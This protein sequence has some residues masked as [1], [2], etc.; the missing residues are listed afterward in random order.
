MLHTETVVPTRNAGFNRNHVFSW[1]F[2]SESGAEPRMGQYACGSWWVAPAVGETGVRL[3]SLVGSQAPM[4]LELLQLSVNPTPSTH[5][6]IY[7]QTRSI[8]SSST[9]GGAGAA[10]NVIGSLPQLYTADAN[11]AISLVACHQLSEQDG[12]PVQSG[13]FSVSTSSPSLQEYSVRIQDAGGLDETVSYTLTTATDVALRDGLLSALQANAN[14]VAAVNLG[15]SGDDTVTFSSKASDDIHVYFPLNTGYGS[16]NTQVL[17]NANR[18]AAAG[19][20]NNL[21]SQAAAYNV[22]TVLRDAPANNGVNHIR[23]NVCG[24]T[25]DILTWDDFDLDLVPTHPNASVPGGGPYTTGGRWRFNCSFLGMS[26]WNGSDSVNHSEG[27][28]AFKPLDLIADY[29]ANAAVTWNNT[30]FGIMSDNITID[31]KKPLLAGLITFGI[32]HWHLRYNL[33]SNFAVWGSGA[34]QRGDEFGPFI[35]SICLLRDKSKIYRWQRDIATIWSTNRP[36]Q[37]PQILKQTHRGQTG[38]RLWGDGWPYAA[39]KQ[40][41][42]WS[43]MMSNNYYEGA[44]GSPDGGEGQRTSADPFGYHEGPSSYPGSNYAMVTAGGYEAIA[45][46]MMLWPAFREC[47][48]TDAPIEYIDRWRRL[49]TWALPDPIAPP[50]ETDQQNTCNTFT[51]GLTCV[52]YSITW[53]HQFGNERYGIRGGNNG[54]YGSLHGLI[55]TFSN[56][57]SSAQNA[58]AY[59]MSLYNGELMEDYLVAVDEL[60]K[61]DMHLYPHPDDDGKMG[62]HMETGSFEAEVRYTYDGSDPVETSPLFN[63]PVYFAEGTLLKARTF[64]SGFSPSAIATKV[65]GLSGE[66]KRNKQ[67]ADGGSL[68][69]VF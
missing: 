38:V 30:I 40:G 67:L 64:K 21:G 4:I 57:S 32:N 17:Q 61:P 48:N 66:K 10:G 62:M 27:G 12:I 9:N 3:V 65:V 19:T 69:A 49:G 24:D 31:Q 18:I 33:S 28:R 36:D 59:A 50:T 68:S 42:Y 6:F 58:W 8:N 41:R 23:P 52:D 54:R 16:F 56:E 26:H 51:G 39:T 15:S 47:V 22:V 35:L 45:C 2:E 7:Q 46:I 13:S 63:G 44:L 37:G 55:R 29:A 11:S 14:V 60:V 5:G 1:T 34:G 25:K 53:G 43:D 20:A